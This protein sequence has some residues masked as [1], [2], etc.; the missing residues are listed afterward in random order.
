VGV[1][2]QHSGVSC[3]EMLAGI[4]RDD[5]LCERPHLDRVRGGG[6]EEGGRRPRSCAGGRKV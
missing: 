3:C 6:G 5:M 2:S 1:L 4:W